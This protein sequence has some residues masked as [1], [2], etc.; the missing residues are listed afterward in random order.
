VI[1]NPFGF[2]FGLLLTALVVLAAF[3]QVFVSPSQALVT[4]IVWR[5]VATL[6]GLWLV[7]LLLVASDYKTQNAI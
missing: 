3:W 5:I 2:A 7:V 1:T 4:R 6:S